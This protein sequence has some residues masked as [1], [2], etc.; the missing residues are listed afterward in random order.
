M[1]IWRAT[2][3]TQ[4][5]SRPTL[6]DLTGRP[7]TRRDFVK[8]SSAVVLSATPLASLLA[9]CGG[10]Q[11]TATDSAVATTDWTAL[12]AAAKKEGSCTFYSANADT[13]DLI[14]SGFQ[15]QYP[16]GLINTYNGG[17]TDLISKSLIEA[18][19]GIHNADV[20]VDNLAALSTLQ[21]AGLLTHVSLPNDA[22]M[23]AGLRDSTNYYHPI[24]QVIIVYCYNTHLG[25]PPPSDPFQLTSSAWK[26]RFAFDAPADEGITTSWL[27]SRKQ[28]WGTTKWMTWLGGLKANN[29]LLTD[30]GG[31]V[32]QDV[33]AGERAAGLGAYNDI[34]TQAAGAPV[35]AAT[36]DNML[37]LGQYGVV[38]RNAPHPNMAR[39]FVNWL[40]SPAGQQVYV[41]T[42][43]T[44]ALNIAGKTSLSSVL[45]LSSP[46]PTVLSATA[47]AR[48]LGANLQNYLSDFKQFWS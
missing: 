43:R 1:G 39:L 4:T 47:E 29:V 35:A 16:W 28:L 6:L 41:K 34:A 45:A 15:A 33:L 46:A 23:P 26:N 37:T 10:S 8:G 36:Y 12:V 22:Q 32:Y 48:D 13:N 40:M 18:R 20:N 30:S 19:A 2:D 31:T 11:A 21:N 3:E 27:A 42:G 17:G 38:Y 24:Y 9:A 7:L 5:P 25:G 14:Q 44:P